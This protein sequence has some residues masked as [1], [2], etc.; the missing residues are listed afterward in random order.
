M[1][2]AYIS[3]TFQNQK[4]YALALHFDL[5][6]ESGTLSFMLTELIILVYFEWWFDNSLWTP[7]KLYVIGFNGI[8]KILWY[9]LL[10]IDSDY[11]MKYCPALLYGIICNELC[12]NAS[13]SKLVI[14]VKTMDNLISLPLAHAQDNNCS[15]QHITHRNIFS[16]VI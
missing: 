15:K 11:S 3:L 5:R 6:C 2:S 7:R 8:A 4:I 12:L 10:V 14:L 16:T 13:F 9:L 1:V